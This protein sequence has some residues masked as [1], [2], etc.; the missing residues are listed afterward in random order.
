M[1]FSTRICYNASIKK[2]HL[3]PK[4][5]VEEGILLGYTIRKVAVGDE[6]ALAYVHTES[7]KAAFQSILSEDV[8]KECTDLTEITAM[9]KH[10]LEENFGNGYI[11][12]I[13]GKAHCIAFWD[14]TRAEDMPGTA[15]IICIHSLQN[16]WGKGYG[17]KMMDRLLDN[18]ASAGFTDVMLWVFVK[19]ERARKFYEANGF[20][21][22]ENTHPAFDSVEICYMK[23]LAALNERSSG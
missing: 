7:W 6:S 23:K 2:L 9:Y 12:E 5:E 20:V 11:L 17:S 21:S 22:T 14:K 8:L 3:E 19:N 18:I 15:E 16:N 1:A 13:D 4:T 10:L